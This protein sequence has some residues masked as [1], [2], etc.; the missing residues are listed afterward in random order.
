MWRPFKNLTQ[1][2]RPSYQPHASDCVLAIHKAGEKGGDHDWSL[3]TWA[4]RCFQFYDCGTWW[5]LY[6]THDPKYRGGKMIWTSKR[7]PQYM[8]LTRRL[9]IQ[10]GHRACT[11]WQD[12]VEL[13]C[14]RMS[15]RVSAKEW[16]AGVVGHLHDVG[17]IDCEA[18]DELQHGLGQIQDN[19]QQQQEE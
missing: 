18:N 17:W 16:V 5:F 11:G 8:S 6:I 3:G 19:G 7:W 2:L 10:Q 13:C 9:N 4:I 12:S 1:I 14:R 15:T